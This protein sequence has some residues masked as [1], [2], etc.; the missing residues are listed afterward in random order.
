MSRRTLKWVAGLSVLTVALVLPVSTFAAEPNNVVPIDRGGNFG[1]IVLEKNCADGLGILDASQCSFN[2]AAPE[3]KQDVEQ[4]AITANVAVPIQVQLQ[5]QENEQKAYAPAENKAI[6]VAKPEAV[7][8]T[9]SG[10]AKAYGHYSDVFIPGL[11]QEADASA[12]GPLT[13]NSDT[14][15]AD[16]HIHGNVDGGNAD[17]GNYQKGEAE[18]EGKYAK[19]ET[20]NAEA[21]GGDGGKAV[22]VGGDNYKTGNAVAIA[23]SKGEADSKGGI[24]VQAAV[25][26]G[27]TCN[28]DGCPNDLNSVDPTG[29]EKCCPLSETEAEIEGDAKA[30]GGDVCVKGGDAGATGGDSTAGNAGNATGGAG[31][32]GGKAIPIALAKNIGDNAKAEQFNNAIS[33]HATGGNADGHDYNGGNTGGNKTFGVITGGTATNVIGIQVNQS[34]NVDAKSGDATNSGSANANSENWLKQWAQPSV[35]QSQN[36]DQKGAVLSATKQEAVTKQ[37]NEQKVSTGNQWASGKAESE[38][39]VD[40]GRFLPPINAQ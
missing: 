16:T 8:V 7:I 33:G 27:V 1:S 39:K 37:E 17:T 22:S 10:D 19:A 29:S 21:N 20:G 5:K 4:K 11:K 25:G 26:V 13:V 18:I 23:P 31:G 34:G 14:G 30:N 40:L 12:E 9:K 36:P 28:K 6:Q 35:N 2:V 3:A 32:D 24:A 38:V 15:S